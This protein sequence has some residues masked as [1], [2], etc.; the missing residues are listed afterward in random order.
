MINEIIYIII[1]RLFKLQYT[2]RF[3]PKIRIIQGKLPRNIIDNLEMKI[4]IHCSCALFYHLMQH[5]IALRDAKTTHV[6]TGNQTCRGKGMN[7]CEKMRSAH[8]TNHSIL[9][10]SIT[11]I[12]EI[13]TLWKQRPP[14]QSFFVMLYIL[15]H[16]IVDWQFN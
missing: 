7:S 14:N 2:F 3:I 5:Q 16:H 6:K 9:K 13:Y 8:L 10:S 12:G 15:N 1:E 4:V 11:R